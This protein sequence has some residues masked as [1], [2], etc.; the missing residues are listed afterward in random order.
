MGKEPASCVSL[1]A[2]VPLVSLLC[3]R[4]QGL[5]WVYTETMTNIE[6]A[7]GCVDKWGHMPWWAYPM[8]FSMSLGVG[9]SA[10]T[11]GQLF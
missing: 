3:S 2:P 6:C 5:G 1:Q 7:G 8:H 9:L 11:L 4:L 10:P